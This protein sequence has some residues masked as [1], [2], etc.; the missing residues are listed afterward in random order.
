MREF[1]HSPPTA[2]CPTTHSRVDIPHEV[3]ESPHQ[4]SV[5]CFVCGHWHL[6]DPARHALIAAPDTPDD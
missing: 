4:Q 2:I 6:W 3:A 5:Y 1:D